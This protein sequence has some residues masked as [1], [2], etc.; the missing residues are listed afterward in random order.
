VGRYGPRRYGSSRGRR[1]YG[2]SR[3][4]EHIQA[5]HRFSAEMGGLDADVK[6]YFFALPAPELGRVLDAYQAAHG[7]P[8]REYAEQAIPKWRTGRVTMSGMVAERL[9]G[10]LP[11][12]MPLQKKYALT[13]GMWRH[14]GPSSKK[15]LRVGLD[16]S[17]E[18]VVARVREHITE[19]VTAY[20]IP[21]AME[22][23]FAW[24]SQGDVTVK[25]Q[26]LNH[27]REQEK[28]LVIGGARAQIALLLDQLRADAQG[29]MGLV[30]HTF[31]VGKHELHVVFERDRQGVVM[32]DFRHFPPPSQQKS[33]ALPWVVGILVF[34]A[35]LLLMAR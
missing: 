9:F 24:L 32:E 4:A 2:N 21:D 30:K 1:F 29:H 3:A 11:R 15:M 18:D 25:Q 20:R 33:D 8:A 22:Q 14:L 7:A 31:I 17:V 35:L 12:F 16:A 26:L 13:E 34:L 6:Q 19:V 5:A 27:L 10:L 28:Q 23:R